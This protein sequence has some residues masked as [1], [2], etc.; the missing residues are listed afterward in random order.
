MIFGYPGGTNRYESSYGVTMATEI[1]NP[2]L[3]KLRDMRLKYMFEEMKKDP[4]TNLQL[5]SSYA[6]IANY[7]KFFDGE[8]KQ[9]LKYDVEGQKRKAEEKF[10]A[11]AKG[12]PAYENIFAGWND[13]YD[14]WRKYAKHRMYMN[15]GIIGTPTSPH[16]L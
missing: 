3:V 13:A 4:A 11:W 14:A 15:E 1:N 8:T 2:T 6:S 16:H 5:S 9:L 7:W 10:I 12:K